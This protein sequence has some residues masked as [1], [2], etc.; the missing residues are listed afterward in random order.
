MS[1]YKEPQPMV[2]SGFYPE[3]NDEFENFEKSLAKLKLNDASFTYE[4]EANEALGRGFRLGFLGILHYEIIT[5]RLQREYGLNL[6]TTVPMVPYKIV[7]NSG[8]ELFV[9]K[10]TDFPDNGKI[11]LIKEPFV[12]LKILAPSRYLNSIISLMPNFR[13]IQTHLETLQ[14]DLILITYE[15]P[16]S[17][18]ILDLYDSLKSATQGF[19]SM[20]YDL[21]DYRETDVQKLDVLIHHN[22]EESLSFIVPTERADREARRLTSKLKDIIPPQSFSLAIQVARDGLII[23]RETIPAMKKDVT[24]YLY[25]GDRTRKMKL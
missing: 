17:E 13:A 21:M 1:G 16:L 9:N 25:G 11:K 22:K 2:F 10:P 23:S 18:L 24:G 7:L 5:L 6:I 4:P 12:E 3:S 19:A 15:L 14:G 20:I 8:E